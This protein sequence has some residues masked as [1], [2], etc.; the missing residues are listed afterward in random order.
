M[1]KPVERRES[2]L[3][4]YFPSKKS[5]KR[6]H[7]TNSKEELEDP[8]ISLRN[9]PKRLSMSEE[10][11]DKSTGHSE[12][13]MREE[14]GPQRVF[15]VV[16]LG[17]SGVGKSSFIQHY[18]S[19]HFPN[20]MAST[21]GMDFQVRCVMLDSTPVALQLW[22]TAGQ[23]RFHSIT[24][25][26]FRRADGIVAMYDVTQETSFMAV[27]HWLDQVQE[28]MTEEACLMLLGNKTDLATGDKRQVTKP[29]GRRLAEYQAEFYECSAKN[30]QHV[31]DAMT[32]LTRLLAS[33]QDKQCEST[34]RLEM[35]SSRGRCCA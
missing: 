4:N 32:H 30:K 3:A 20:N 23:E 21:V 1:K 13:T 12:R 28:K 34:L 6:H 2:I 9:S 7:I 26:Y 22:D 31:E 24:Q 5:T 18:S 27:R 16:F 35:S 19:G 15:K 17:N 14:C 29:Q 11:E 25:Q 33:Q 10:T 8:D